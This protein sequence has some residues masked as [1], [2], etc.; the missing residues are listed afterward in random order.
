MANPLRNFVLY[1]VVKI[2]V[3]QVAVSGL[4]L[5]ALIMSM[6]VPGGGGGGGVG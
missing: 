6:I 2:S 4:A 3:F 5:G 1:L